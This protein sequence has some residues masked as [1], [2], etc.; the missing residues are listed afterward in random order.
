LIRRLIARLLGRAPRRD[1]EPSKVAWSW[2]SSELLLVTGLPLADRWKVGLR[3]GG[4][5]T[6]LE[7]RT[8]RFEHQARGPA[9]V[10][11]VRLPAA[12]AAGA[13]LVLDGGRRRRAEISQV[14]LHEDAVDL[15]VLAERALAGGTRRSREALEAALVA[16]SLELLE[17]SEGYSLAGRLNL[18]RDALSEPLGERMI[19]AQVPQTVFVDA[20]MA[21]DDRSFWIAGWV[22]DADRS[23]TSLVAVSPEGQRVELLEGSFRHPRPDVEELFAGDS[24]QE[25]DHGFVK[26]VTLPAPSPLDRGWTV[27][28]RTR[29]GA[30]V[31]VSGPEVVRDRTEVLNRILSEFEL[32]RTGRDRLRLEHVRPALERFQ[33][34]GRHAVAVEDVRDFGAV[35]DA[36]RVSVVVPLYER[37]D[38]VEHQLAQFGGDPQFREVELVYVLDSPELGTELLAV[39]P[40]LHALHQVPFRLVRLSRNGGFSLANNLGVAETRAPLVLLLNSDVLPTQPEWL[41]RMAAFYDSTPDIGALGAKLLFEDDSIQHAGMYFQRDIESQVWGNRHYFKGFH[42]DFAEGRISRPVPAVTGACLM[43]SRALYDA[44]GGLSA[45]YVRGGYEDS[46]LCIRLARD[47]KRNWY[48]ADVELYHLEAQSYPSPVRRLA[49]LYNAWLQ[50][51]LWDAEIESLAGAHAESAEGALVASAEP[52]DSAS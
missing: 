11:L 40:H 39:A 16:D 22:R 15:Q 31:E 43:I 8:L 32:D 27:E 14:E 19:D 20:I 21:V 38:F 50:T 34:H 12:D 49:T 24:R 23:A 44:Y 4:A 3:R 52:S 6:Q 28:L 18:L 2:L 9:T 33:E 30:G 1:R 47:G 25:T 36:P 51:H 29:V 7:A 10:L 26:Y 45:A 35:P 46:D 5:T 42:R 37:V 17:R 48:F 41:L 13:S